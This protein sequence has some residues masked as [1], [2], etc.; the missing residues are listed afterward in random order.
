MIPWDHK[1]W[2]CH[3][4]I[5]QLEQVVPVGVGVHGVSPGDHV[6]HDED[7]LGVVVDVSDQLHGVSVVFGQYLDSCLS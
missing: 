5:L 3:E 4:H 7:Q 6:Q 2:P 1:V